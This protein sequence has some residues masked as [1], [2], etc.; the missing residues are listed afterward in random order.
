MTSRR[1]S[2]GCRLR[3][4]ARRSDRCRLRARRPGHL[5]GALPRGRRQRPR[6]RWRS[7]GR[8]AQLSR[9][10]CSKAR[11]ALWTGRSTRARLLGVLPMRALPRSWQRRIRNGSGARAS[12]RWAFANV[13]DRE[14]ADSRS[15]PSASARGCVHGTRGGAGT[16][17]GS[18]CWTRQLDVTLPGT[19][20]PAGPAPPAD[21]DSPRGR[22]H[23]PRARVRDRG[24][25]RGRDRLAQ[26]RCAQP[27]VDASLEVAP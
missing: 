4:S 21:P 24:Q 18:P 26:L 27:A 20:S 2:R 15:T 19:A 7:R 17:R 22:G 5:S 11:F 12:S 8:T 23:L 10:N 3:R 25:S 6:R 1:R 14:Y 13:R 9:R 16:C